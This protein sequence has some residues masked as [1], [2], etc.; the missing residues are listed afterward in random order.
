MQSLIVIVLMVIQKQDK[1]T[2]KETWPGSRQVCVLD[3]SHPLI[4]SEAPGRGSFSLGSSDL[5]AMV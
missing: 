5:P 2:G 3:L 4:T 1:G